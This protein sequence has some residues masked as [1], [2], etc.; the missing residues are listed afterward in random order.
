MDDITGQLVGQEF[1]PPANISILYPNKE[2]QKSPMTLDTGKQ[3]ITYN[4][5][6]IQL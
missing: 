6:T 2:M 4:N 1:Q 3:T 5:Q